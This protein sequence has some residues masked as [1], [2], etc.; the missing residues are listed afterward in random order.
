M[1]LRRIVSH[2]LVAVVACV[3]AATVVGCSGGNN[4]QVEAPAKF[5]PPPANPPVGA[6]GA[7]GSKKPMTGSRSGESGKAE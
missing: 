5:A 1:S 7:K 2:G 3:P 4:N 6:G